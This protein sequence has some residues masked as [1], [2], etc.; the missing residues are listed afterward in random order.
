MSTLA[1]QAPGEVPAQARV[2]APDE[3][4]TMRGTP[5]MP[6]ATTPDSGPGAIPVLDMV[7][8]M[9]GF[10]EHR[11]FALARLDEEGTVC[12]LRSLE[13][14]DLRFVV[15]PPSLF[16]DDYTPEVADTVA[17]SLRAESGD[18]LVALVV[19]TLG[20]ASGDATANL[21]APVLVNPRHRLAAQVVLDD[22]DLPVRA[23]LLPAGAAA[24]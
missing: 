4:D 3:A 2:R 8:P 11:R 14:T 20:E 21:L 19:V 7:S 1:T 24:R 18:D 16:F 6:D 10:P 13:D 23:P 15:V 9:L 17:E 12:D 5:T 22:A